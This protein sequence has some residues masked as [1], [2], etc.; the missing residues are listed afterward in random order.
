MKE[1]TKFEID[2]DICAVECDFCDAFLKVSDTQNEKCLVEFPDAKNINAGA[3]DG[4]IFISQRK[5]RLFS[6][7]QTVLLGVPAHT[8]P[9]LKI[10][11]KNSNFEVSGGIYADFSLNAESGEVKISD[12]AFESL[13]IIGGDIDVKIINCTVKNGLYIKLDKGSVLA[14]DSFATRC[15]YRIRHGNVGLFDMTSKECVAETKKGNV[16]AQ[17]HGSEEDFNYSV[18]SKDGTANRSDKQNDGAKYG[19]E[20]YSG[21]GNVVLEFNQPTDTPTVEEEQPTV[22]EKETN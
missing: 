21:E 8:V 14:E 1:N 5:R 2:G 9:D 3:K 22:E 18:Y 16:T 20:V 4:T 19:V 15:E 17:M 6:G 10:S 11:A 13:E 12:C 7:K